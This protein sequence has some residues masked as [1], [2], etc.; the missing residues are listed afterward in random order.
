M[1]SFFQKFKQAFLHYLLDTG[2]IRRLDDL[3][4]QNAQLKQQIELL[5]FENSV[6][7]AKVLDELLHHVTIGSSIDDGKLNASMT[8]LPQL[9]PAKVLDVKLPLRD[10]ISFEKSKNA[11]NTFLYQIIIYDTVLNR[12]VRYA[13]E[14]AIDTANDAVMSG[15]IAERLI[16]GLRGTLRDIAVTEFLKNARKSQSL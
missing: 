7:R 2:E 10:I 12:I 3:R 16:D 15:V 1:P 11:D 9:L 13:Y 6:M 8:H 4:A 5:T 14:S